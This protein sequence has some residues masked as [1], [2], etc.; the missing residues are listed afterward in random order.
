VSLKPGGIGG[1]FNVAVAFYVAVLG[2]LAG[3][4]STAYVPTSAAMDAPTARSVVEQ[5]L[6]RSNFIVGE[7]APPSRVFDVRVRSD[8]FGLA[9]QQASIDWSLFNDVKYTAP[10]MVICSFSAV[11]TQVIDFGALADE[12]YRWGIRACGLR[13]FPGDRNSASRLADA[14]YVLKVNAAR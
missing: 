9:I 12:P 14:F 8:A 1:P 4:E 6:K 7:L 3:C 13:I 10:G 2:V 11:S 5:T